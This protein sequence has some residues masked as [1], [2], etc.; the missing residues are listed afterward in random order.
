MGPYD[1]EDDKEDDDDDDDDEAMVDG[2]DK[3]AADDDDENDE[4]DE[5]GGMRP[6]PDGISPQRWRVL[7]MTTAMTVR[8]VGEDA[9]KMLARCRGDLTDL[10]PF[11]Q[12]QRDL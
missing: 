5:R 6:M 10:N 11:I 9:Y 8:E 12:W 7:M 3:S 1:D 2:L 4:N